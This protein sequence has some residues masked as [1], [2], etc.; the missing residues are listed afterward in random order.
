MTRACELEELG[1]EIFEDVR[2][3]R[4]DDRR[5]AAL[6]TDEA[7][8]SQHSE[9]MRQRRLRQVERIRY[10][11]RRLRALPQHLEDA[12]ARRIGQGSEGIGHRS[13]SIYLDIHRTKARAVSLCPR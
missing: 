7:R 2:L 3:Q 6:R 13:T 11:P 12:A 1:R 9:V 10:L 5:A 4:V 8:A